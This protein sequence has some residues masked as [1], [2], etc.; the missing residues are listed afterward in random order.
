MSPKSS[1]SPDHY[2]RT[3]H[4]I[5]AIGGRTARGGF[6]TMVAH[7]MKFAVSIVAT[8]ILARLLTPQ[9]YGLIG[10]VA[11]ATNFVSLFKDLGL[12]HVTIQ[13]SEINYDQISTL[14]WVNVAV[15]VGI[16]LLMMLAAPA[17]SWFF[18]EPRL[19]MITA[20]TALGFVLGGLA[21]Q[22]E[23]LLKRQMKFFVLSMIAFASMTFGYVVG[24][25]LA[26]Y[27]ARYWALVFSQL[28]LL[29]ANTVGLWLACHWRPGRPRHD[30]NTKSMLTFGGNVTGY[31]VVNYF[32][33]NTDNLLIGRLGGSQSL[34]L[35]NKASQLL[36]LPTDQINEPLS[37]VTIPALSRLLDA[38]ER[39]RQAYLRIMEKV[40]LVTMP[41]V[42]L[43]IVAADWLVHVV[44]G[45]QWSAAAPILIFMSISGLF[46]PVI[47]TGGWVLVTQG[48]TRE[49]VHW[50]II[51]API[52][53][54]SII[55]GLRWGAVGVAA[56]YSL[57]RLLLANPLMFWFIG[58][59]GPVRTADFYRLLAPFT[60]AV[61]AAMV[62]C[63]LFRQFVVVTNPLVGL[64]SSAIIIGLVTLLV[65]CLIPRGRSALMDLKTSLLLL[66]PVTP[67]PAQ[68]HE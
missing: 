45:P 6:V 63:L 17:V 34:G 28:A 50:S 31:S 57:S 20:V 49:M 52:A 39:Y 36:G 68:A 11:V 61:G 46:T 22:H 58:R 51:N 10:M 16:M 13:R 64:T 15:S 24:I 47:N 37:A 2:F 14:F 40:V 9:D 62:A 4:L 8:A 26:W 38:P 67:T 56:S 53:I 21:V 35:Y 55:I 66:K 30:P 41:V 29:T 19:S 33:R 48:R 65:L 27:G 12:S 23:A 44:L 54:L 3:D 25:V 43:M 18:G 5:S 60:C 59:S 1:N 7:G 42:A 32:S